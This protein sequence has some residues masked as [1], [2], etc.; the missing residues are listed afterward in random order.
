MLLYALLSLTVV[1]MAPVA[2]AMSGSHARAPTLA[3]LGW[4][5]PRGLAS[6]VFATIAVEESQLPHEHTMVVIIFLT[7]GI[8]VFAHGFS[9]APLARRYSTWYGRHPSDAP[10]R[11]ESAPTRV[12]RAR[13]SGRSSP[14]QPGTKH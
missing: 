8:S 2:V 7:V 1:R 4:F 11:M 6:I 14:G 12:T 3:F 5:G 10:P 13:L 9:A